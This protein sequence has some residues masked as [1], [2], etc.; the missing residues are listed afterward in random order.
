MKP[1]SVSLEPMDAV[2]DADAPAV[3]LGAGYAGLRL[4]HEV[5]RLSDRTIP[6]TLVDRSPVHVLRTELY[7]VGALAAPPGGTRRFT[8]PLEELVRKDGIVF[9]QGTVAGI[10]LDS[11]VVDLG[12]AKLRFRSLAICLGSV[13]AFYGVPGAETNTFQVYR[14]SGAV[15][16]AS[17][18]RELELNSASL[19]AA[20]RPRVLVIGGGSTGTEVAA[21]IAT[22]D[23]PQIA[24]TDVRPPEVLLVCGALPFLAGFSPGLIRHARRMLYEAGVVVHEGVNAK[25]I[26]PH[27][28]I[29]EDGTVFPFD[30]AVWAAGVQA[31]D[32]VRT[33]PVA[34]GHGG[35]LKVDAHL[36]LPERPGVFGVGDAIEFEDPETH[37]L[38]PGTAQ[39]ALAEAPVAAENLV[40]RWQGRSMRPFHYRERGVVV[41]LG[42]GKAAA[43]LSRVTIWG[44]PAR[45]L[46]TLVEKEYANATE[47]GRSPPGL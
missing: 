3:V 20:R 11:R 15:K 16:L 24:G 9:R 6:V 23:W 12:E 1:P 14:Y 45:L 38:V 21:E 17:A 31:P 27:Q 34:H 35:R 33:L 32:V 47:H 22:A 10:D 46:K 43:K 7:H 39:A 28:A 40:A 13:A 4:A 44:S 26:E 29:L 41:A 42:V 36:E 19:P 25:A 30:V 5:R 37:L 2:P 8:L 18:M